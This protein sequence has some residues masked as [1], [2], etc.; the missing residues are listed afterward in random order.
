ME[1]NSCVKTIGLCMIV[2][3]EA[4]LIMRCLDSVRSLVDYV[5]VSDTGSTDGTQ[6]MIRGWLTD[7]GI[8]GTVFD[9]P[10]VD[11]AHN[12]NV[13]LSRLQRIPNIDYSMM[14]D[15]DD[16]IEYEEDFNPEQFKTGLTAD[17]YFVSIRLND[18]YYARILLC[19]TRQPYRY[20]G[21]LH[22]YIEVPSERLTP[23]S[24]K[25]IK[26]V[27]GTEGARSSDPEKYY[28]DAEVLE[29]ALS[30]E[31]DP[32]LRARYQ[33]YLAQSCR[34]CG[35]SEKALK[36]YLA[37]SEL[38]FW[39]EE[40]YISLY[41]AARLKDQ[42][43]H[44]EQEVIDTYLR[45]ADVLPARAEALH[46]ASRF[47]RLHERYEQGYR[48]AGRGLALSIPEDGLFIERW[49]Y[50]QGLLDEYAINAYWSGHFQDCLDACLK[51]LTA[52]NLS[53]ADAQRIA[54]NAKFASDRL[55]AQSQA[56]ATPSKLMQPIAQWRRGKSVPRVL[57]AI[58]AKQKEAVLP[59]YLSCIDA[60][61]YPKSSIVLYVRTNNNTD[62]TEQILSS[63]LKRVGHAYAHVEYETADAPE[64]VEQFDVHEWNAMRFRVLAAI[65]QDSLQ[66]T[67]RHDCDFYFVADVDNFLKPHTLRS[68]LATNLPIVAPLLR[69]QDMLRLYS[70]YHQQVDAH[71]YFLNSEA[72]NW[73]LFQQVKGLIEVPVVHC[74]YLIRRDVIPQLHY[75]DGSDR[76]E[77]V[78]FS[79]SARQSGV[80]QYL[81]NRDI[82]GY[83]TLDEQ[84]AP[85]IQLLGESVAIASR[86]AD[87][88]TTRVKRDND[89][90]AAPSV[91][92]HASWRTSSTWIW[93]KFRQL[94]ETQAFYEPFSMFLHHMTRQQA[95]SFAYTSWGSGHS[96]TDPYYLEYL[97]LIRQS[98]GMKRF[99]PSIPY[100]WFFPPQGLRG[101]LRTEE[102]RYVAL[103][104]K[105]AQRRGRQPVLGFCRSL[106][107][108]WPLKSTFG[109]CH[110][111]LYRNLWLHW[112]S[113]VSLRNRKEEFFYETVA[114]LTNR[115]NEP[116]MN[117]LCNRYL[118]RSERFRNEGNLDHWIGTQD[119][120][121]ALLSLPEHEAFGLFMGLHLYLYLHAW[122]TVDLVLDMTRLAREQSYRAHA[123]HELWQRTGLALNFADAREGQ[124]AADVN[125]NGIDWAEIAELGNAAADMLSSIGDRDRLVQRAKTM[126]DAAREEAGLCRHK[127]QINEIRF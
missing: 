93:A 82:Y 88:A 14:M 58:L 75:A 34:D 27:A 32:F 92:L 77:Y 115:S 69:Y 73:L 80:P 10:W 48:I 100:K 17:H 43:A 62:R 26:I 15:A 39:Q 63:W 47:C 87:C 105:E 125:A 51:I 20:R 113:Y 127:S 23:G 104:L 6:D 126:V 33:F 40:I 8:P 46:G 2:K 123:E 18:V 86:K 65:R 122:Q 42:L 21:V 79:D 30:Q 56:S 31:T 89:T 74:T 59:F 81:D 116:F 102:K 91:F 24:V 111:M 99:H 53:E 13:I 103:L 83:L 119:S 70:N 4:A 101:D 52:G 54:T 98:G 44:P 106:G 36:H 71:G 95:A 37:R 72:Y 1:K 28:R 61:D 110:I 120:Y 29:T 107:R 9:D 118:P 57:I 7:T 109:G 12:R 108:V 35:E 66:A 67:L 117:Y 114:L 85:S 45:A 124:A 5:L 68:L 19:S 55:S 84:I 97:P 64:P 121:D 94:P 96:A 41:Q 25:S 90:V 78:I 112:A 50:S 49:I 76:H 3:N 60:L 16:F 11:F 38:G 22:E